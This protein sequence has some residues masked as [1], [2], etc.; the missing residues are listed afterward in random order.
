MKRARHSQ[1][2]PNEGHAL[3]VAVGWRRRSSGI[4]GAEQAGGDSRL[5]RYVKVGMIPLRLFALGKRD[6]A[7]RNLPSRL[8]DTPAVSITLSSLE[9]TPQL[10]K[11]YSMIGRFH[12]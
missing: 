7:S 2:Q 5:Q 1:T 4:D 12:S 3:Q 6:L 10:R 8:P 11:R 9:R